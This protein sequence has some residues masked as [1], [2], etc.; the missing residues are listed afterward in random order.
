MSSNDVSLGATSEDRRGAHDFGVYIIFNKQLSSSIGHLAE[1]YDSFH[2]I[3]CLNSLL[4]IYQ[5]MAL[6]SGV[7]VDTASGEIR[8]G[9]N[10]TVFTI[11]FGLCGRGSR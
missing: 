1:R 5:V 4:T 6:A 9:S 7:P 3:R 2:C 11:I 8:V 10:P